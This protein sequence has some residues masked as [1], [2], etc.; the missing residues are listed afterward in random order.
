MVSKGL[1][2]FQK[3]VMLATTWVESSLGIRT[4]VVAAHVVLNTQ[5][6]F[7]NSA[8]DGFLVKLCRWSNL[9]FMICVLF[10]AGKARIVLVTALEFDDD[11]I[12]LGM[13]TD[14]ESGCRLVCQRH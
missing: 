2:L 11:D 4:G 8:Q 6:V 3:M 9:M 13:P 5:L 14:I 1:N 10:M 12:Q 7:A